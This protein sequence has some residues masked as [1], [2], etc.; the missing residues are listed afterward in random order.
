MKQDPPAPLPLPRPGPRRGARLAVVFAGVAALAGIVS[1]AAWV[2][3]APRTPADAFVTLQRRGGG[4]PLPV[5][6]RAPKV[7]LLDTSGQR[8]TAATLAGRVWIVDFIYTA[9]TSACPVLTA[10]MVLLQRQ[11]TSPRLRFVSISVDPDHDS[12]AVLREYASHWRPDEKRWLLL[13]PSREELSA[14]AAGMHIA[15]G[16]GEDAQNPI[17]HSALFSLVDVAGQVRGV[18]DAQDPEAMRRLVEDARELLA[19]PPAAAPGASKEGEALLADLGCAGCHDRPGLA[20]SLHGLWG[21]PV[22]LASGE[23]VLADESY[24]RE[25]ILNPGA[26]L[27]AG[28]APLMPSYAEALSAAQLTAVLDALQHLAAPV[29][30]GSVAAS[31]ASAEDPVCHMAVATVDDGLRVSYRGATYHF[32]S[33]RCREAFL[34]QPEKYLPSGTAKPSK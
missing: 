10:K 6:W 28:Y 11:L 1:L 34:R 7:A 4:A 16:P 32:C 13:S 9:C 5:L 30:P 24:L 20:P 33:T 27:V 21:H 23:S 14:L 22:Q 31:T 29:S 12:P 26:K 17:L 8:T 25:S 3:T 18:Y 19:D 2:L 15:V